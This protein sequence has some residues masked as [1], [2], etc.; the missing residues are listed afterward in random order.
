MTTLP[1]LVENLKT[2]VEGFATSLADKLAEINT[3]KDDLTTA[4]A[5]AIATALAWINPFDL[6]RVYVDAINGD[7]ANDGT[8]DSPI[9]T[10][11]KM[12]SFARV[13]RRFE[14]ELM[15]DIVADHLVLWRTPPS[16]IRFTGR[17]VDGVTL[18]QRKMTFVD[19]ANFPD[20]SSYSGGLYSFTD[21]NVETSNVSFEMAGTRTFSPVF[22]RSGHLSLKAATGLITRTGTGAPLFNVTGSAHFQVTNVGIDPSASGHVV[23]GVAAGGDP[24]AYPGYSANFDQA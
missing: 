14:V 16:A 17:D 19:A 21:M 2:Q 10:W 22:V 1:E 15:S 7:D 12:L 20:P 23:T 5:D 3:A 11:E 18:S 13:G 6:D 4:A 8:K 9:Q 24:N